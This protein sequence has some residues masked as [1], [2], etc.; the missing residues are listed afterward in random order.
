MA[1]TYW[2]TPIVHD[3]YREAVVKGVETYREQ[4]A[5]S[6]RLR[7]ADAQVVTVCSFTGPNGPGYWI[8]RYAARHASDA[9][10][11]KAATLGLSEDQYEALRQVAIEVAYD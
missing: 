9:L 6:E 8:A 7:P 10:L 5:D 1:E 3:L 4:I 11:M 2:G